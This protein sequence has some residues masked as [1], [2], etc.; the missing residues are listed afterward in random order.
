M[1]ILIVD[2]EP[3]ARSRLRALL[4]D[5]RE[6]EVLG[7]AGNGR[8]AIERCAAL[9]PDVVLLDIR[10]PGMDGLE[11]A[12]HIAGAP[13]P[14]A[15]IFTTAY[16]DHA[17][18][19]FESRAVDYLLKPVRAAR[20]A[21]ALAN[22]RRHTRAQLDVLQRTAAEE[23]G[24]VRTHICARVRNSLK[25]V[26]TDTVF[27]FLAEHK[28]VT[29]RHSEGELLIEEALKD[30]AEEFAA[31]FT[32]VHRNA[33]VADRYIGGLEKTAEGRQVI[34]FRGIEDRIEVSRRHLAQVR[35]K[36]RTP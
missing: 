3:L 7:E 1:K 31:A 9:E 4:Q 6:H 26:A 5:M 30:L 14:P 20:L 17:L 16:D 24:E 18:A 28:Y 34:T 33:L 22:A 21:A 11:A 27:Y 23:G 15:V 25:L 19:A 10:M 2:D 35:R 12:R 36:L 32:R 29:V 8:E 13:L